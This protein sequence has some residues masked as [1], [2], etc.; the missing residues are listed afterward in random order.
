MLLRPRQ[1]GSLDPAWQ[2]APWTAMKTTSQNK[3]SLTA[4]C[5][6]C[7]PFT[8]S[9]PLLFTLSPSGTTWQALQ[10]W[11]WRPPIAHPRLRRCKPGWIPGRPQARNVPSPDRRRTTQNEK[12]AITTRVSACMATLIVSILS[13]LWSMWRWGGSHIKCLLSWIKSPLRFM[14]GVKKM[15]IFLKTPSNVG[16]TVMKKAPK[17]Q[18]TYSKNGLNIIKKKKK[19]C[20]PR[21]IKHDHQ[22]LETRFS[23]SCLD[24]CCFWKRFSSAAMGH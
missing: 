23:R 1:A 18:P 14:L 24:F 21:L 20:T 6:A 19:S 3:A 10:G 4:S 7:S 15:F 8:P 22:E 12:M 16:G 13:T 11:G 17:K 5:R 9:A 2:R